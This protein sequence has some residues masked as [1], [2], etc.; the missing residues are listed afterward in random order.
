[1]TELTLQTW[2]CF[3]AAQTLGS[4]LTWR[5]VVDAHRLEHP[6][7]RWNV[8]E[9]DLV[10]MQELFLSDAEAFFDRLAHPH[11]ARDEN[12]TRFWPPTLAGSGLG[13]ASRFPIK[14]YSLRPFSRPQASSERF[15]RKGILHVR[16]TATTTSGSELDLITTHMQSG[17][18]DRARDV[19]KRQLAE[20][21]SVVDEHGSPDRAFIICGDFNIYDLK[22]GRNGEYDALRKT[23][24]DF[25]DLGEDSDAPTFHPDP[26][27]N[28]LAHRYDTGAKKQRLDY[29]LFRPARGG[30]GPSPMSYEIA[31]KERLDGHGPSTFASDHFAVRAK[32]RF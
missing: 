27:H 21:R 2:N 5:G 30:G 29:V 32:F 24:F 7:V 3:G 19:R 16:V 22:N 15:A 20:L 12:G 6:R 28:S 13:I 26:D 14:T 8:E 31:L 17:Y 23:L 18:D 10:C 25:D 9:P 11:K 4:V 1:M